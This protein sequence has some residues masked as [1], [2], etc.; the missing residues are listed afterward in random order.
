MQLE[1]EALEA[2]YK[3]IDEIPFD[4]DRKMMTTIHQDGEHYLIFVKGALERLL[5]L[6]SSLEVNGQK[7][8]MTEA[9][10]EQIL[11]A[12]DQMASQALRVLGVAYKKVPR[13]SFRKAEAEKE[14][15]FLGLTGMID[16]PREE[17]KDSI[18]QCQTAGIQVVMITGDHQQTALAIAKQLGIAEDIQETVT[19]QVLNETSDSQLKE[20]VKTI[21]VFARVSPEHKVRIVKAL[22]ANN[23]VVSMTGDGVNDAPSLRAADVGVAMGI[24]GTDVAKGASDVVLTD[25][26]FSTI[27]AAIEEGRSIY[28]NIKKSI[29]FLL[30]CN[31]GEIITLFIGILMGWPAPL[32]A[33][34]ILWVNLIT[35]TLPAISLGVDPKEKDLMRHPP[36]SSKEGIFVR[37]DVSFIIW[38]GV[39]IGMLTLFA[40]MEGLKFSSDATSLWTMNLEALSSEAVSHAQ[41]LAFLTLSISQLFHAFNLRSR[42]QSILQVGLFSN[43]YLFGAVA[44]GLLLQVG[45]VHLPVLNDWFHLQP[46]SWQE[47]L[48]VLGLSLIPLFL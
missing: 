28:Q 39:L 46:I 13:A 9:A 6:S 43:P 16:P 37:E 45:L 7:E 47:W 20:M 35:D 10:K 8:A 4:S 42:E 5:P 17:V 2:S 12:V 33:I 25:D 21:K 18:A 27:T 44:L 29:L 32:T 3:R 11:Q 31:L 40:F 41:T 23:Q 19:G 14:L 1:K 22:K 36:R 30:S 48:F 24:T 15:S 38:N 34:H 26:N